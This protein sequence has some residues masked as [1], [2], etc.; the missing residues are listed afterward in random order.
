[1]DNSS[2][3]MFAVV[4]VMAY[5]M[6]GAQTQNSLAATNVT[7]AANVTITGPNITTNLSTTHSPGVNITINGTMA[8]NKTMSPTAVVP[9]V[10]TITGPN[11]TTNLS[12]THSPGVNITI[13]GTMAPNTTMSPTAVVPVVNTTALTVN[14]SM[15]ECGKTQLCAAQPVNCNPAVAGSCFFVSTQQSSGQTFFFQL[16]GMSSGYIAVGLSK[17]STQDSNATAF[18]CA[19][20]NGNVNFFTALLDKGNLTYNTLPVDSV[21]GSVNDQTIQCTFSATVP[22]ATATRSIDTSF[23]LSIFNGSFINGILGRPNVVLFSDKAVDLS[24]PQNAV[25]NSLNTI[26]TTTA[27]PSTTSSHAFGLQHTLSQAL[28]ILL[29]VL[30]M[31]ML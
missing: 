31:M 2:R 27:A 29:G 28:L 1:M 30:G 13:N 15:T 23:Y 3:L 14:I 7:M 4:M 9:V 10:N 25:I 22:K 17:T 21:K 19:N 12:T 20:N 11:I 18:V 5:M 6:M 26:T 24:N 16:R 8:P